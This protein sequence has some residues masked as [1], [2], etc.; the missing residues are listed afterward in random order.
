MLPYAEVLL[1]PASLV[2]LCLVLL[3][4]VFGQVG[5]SEGCRDS[6]YVIIIVE[7]KINDGIHLIAQYE[8]SYTAGY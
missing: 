5:I 7:I 3:G 4:R 1:R 2:A 6:H 8:S